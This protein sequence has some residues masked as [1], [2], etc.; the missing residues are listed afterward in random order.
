MHIWSYSSVH[1][2]VE[3]HCVNHWFPFHS[4]IL[5]V[6]CPAPNLLCSSFAFHV[7]RISLYLETLTHHMWL[8]HRVKCEN[9]QTNPVVI[10]CCFS[11]FDGESLYLEWHERAVCVQWAWGHYAQRCTTW[12]VGAQR[13][14][15]YLWTLCGEE[16]MYGKTWNIL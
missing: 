12:T 1:R 5:M 6:Q 9:G 3:G 11:G 16:L 2:T 10:T 15:Q 14:P 4:E 13:H 8:G 7:N